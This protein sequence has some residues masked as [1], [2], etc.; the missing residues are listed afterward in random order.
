MPG[1]QTAAAVENFGRG[2]TP[3]ELVRAYGEVK[4]AVFSAIHELRPY[5]PE[6]FAALMNAAD[7][8]IEGRHDDL[9][10]LELE[11]G[12]AGTSLHMNIN[13]VFTSLLAEKNNLV[14]DPLEE[15]ARYQSTNDTFST[16]VIVAV[17]RILR[18]TEEGVIALQERLVEKEQAWQGI[19]IAGRTELQTAL[20]MDLCQVAGAWNGMIER[21]RWRFHKLK[22]R[23]RTIPLGG[24]A[25]GTGF[26]APRDYV[27][28]AEQKLRE[29]TGLPLSRNQNLPDG[30]ANADSL[31]EAAGGFLLL[32][33][34]L[35]KI[36]GDLLLYTSAFIGEMKHPNLQYGSSIMPAKTN[37][38]LLEHTKGLAI[39]MQGECHKIQRYAEEGDLQLN[40]FLPFMLKAFL[41]IKRYTRMAFRSLS[42]MLL[43]DIEI[44]R[45]IIEKNLLAS[46]IYW[47]LLRP[48]IGYDKAKS[49]SQSPG[50]GKIASMGELFAYVSAETGIA[51]SKIEAYLD[52][53][54]IT[55]FLREDP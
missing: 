25:V 39:A 42:D 1:K 3:R 5:P 24:T 27:F 55:G 35:Y 2:Q 23:L 54:H 4:K 9:F 21:D 38:V 20:P 11:Q 19:V 43:P 14:L 16:A 45:D 22:E 49:L 8:I 15:G 7:E 6:L 17:Y 50:A 52:T 18:E 41:E 13:E 37:P 29:I 34:N 32:A 28:K 10:P 31:A 44:R 40:A 12:G 36:A 33:G 30:I 47:N 46:P 53:K 26:F 48:L 51:V